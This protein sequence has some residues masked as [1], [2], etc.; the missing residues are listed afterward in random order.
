ME[1]LNNIWNT[2]STPNDTIINIILVFCVFIENFLILLLFAS[3]L[4]IRLQKEK[5]IIYM[6][7]ICAFSFI[8]MFLISNPFNVFVNYFIAIILQYIIF[9]PSFLKSIVATVFS[10]IIFNLIGI[11]ILNPF[12]TLFNIDSN[13]LN[14]I[15][16]YRICYLA[17]IY[18]ITS[19][20]VIILKHKSFKFQFLD[21]VDK[22]NKFIIIV[23]LC[24][25]ILAIIT[26]SITLFYYVDNLPVIITFLSFIFLLVYF[27]ISIYSLTRVFKLILT[28]KKLE[29]AEEYNR[30]LR[31]LHDN[32]RAF[33]H[34]FDNIV[35]T[36]GGYIR[37]NDMEGLKDYYIQLEDDCQRVNNLYLLNPEVINNDGIYNL[38]TKKYQEADSKDIKVNMTFLL[39][40]ST[41]HMKIYEFTRILGILLDNAIEASSESEEKIINIDFR[42]DKRNSRQIILIE[43]TYKDKNVDTDKIYDKGFSSKENH[44]GLGLWEV[45]KLVK[46]NNNVNLYTSKTDKYFSQQLEIYY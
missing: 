31:I 21:D 13:H 28:T 4:N 12:I 45:R 6:F 24:F 18:A 9:K 37:T 8:T 36:I 3:I 43:N 11:L 38:L 27:A 30:S 26:Q 22:R 2:I 5:V 46:K 10:L 7:S 17:I 34:D 40:L 25:G 41:L 15:P 19:I 14:S 44:S 16:I 1:I 32:V 23:N 20:V 33:K 39:D 35:T 42:D 29:N